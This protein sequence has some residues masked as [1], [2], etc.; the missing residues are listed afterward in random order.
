MTKFCTVCDL[1]KMPYLGCID[2]VHTLDRNEKTGLYTCPI[3]FPRVSNDSGSGAYT[4]NEIDRHDGAR[5]RDEYPDPK[6]KE[7]TSVEEAERLLSLPLFALDTETIEVGSR[8]ELWSIQIT[9][10]T[11]YGY[12]I[13]ISLWGRGDSVCHA[14]ELFIKISTTS[15]VIVHNYLYDAKFIS[16]PNPIDTMIAA[17]LL[18]IP[19]GLKTLA[20]VL[21]GMEMKDYME[22]VQPY[23]RAVAMGYL[24]I[25][26]WDEYEDPPELLDWE[27]SN[28][29]RQ[30]IQS[31]KKPQNIGTKIRARIKKAENNPDFDVYKAWYDIDERER[32]CVEDVL[33]PMRDAG[34]HDVPHDEAVYYSSRDPD[35]TWRVCQKLMLMLRENGLEQVFKMEMAMLPVCLE[36]MQNGMA[37]DVDKL[38]ELADKCI[39]LMQEQ[40][41]KCKDI[42]GYG[43]N[44]NSHDQV[45]QLVYE[46]LGFEV[47]KK[48]KKAKKA[49]TNDKELSKIKH[50]VIKPILEYRKIL[51]VRSSYAEKLPRYVRQ[52]TTTNTGTGFSTTDWIVYPNIKLA[53]T[54]TGRLKVTDPPLQTI[55]VRTELGREVRDAF[56]V[57]PGKQLLFVD[58]C[59]AEGTLVDTPYGDVAIEDLK[60]G[61]IIYSYGDRRPKAAYVKGR[62][63]SGIQ[64]CWKI[65]LDNGESFIATAGHKVPRLHEFQGDDYNLVSV[66]DLL[67]GDRLLPLKRVY[68]NYRSHM[69]SHKAIEYTKEALTVSQLVYGA[70]PEGY[71]VDHIDGN[72]GNDI[73]ENLQ[74]LLQSEHRAKDSPRSYARQD[75][76]L[77]LEKLREALRTKRDYRGYLNLRYGYRKGP[78]L[79]CLYC[80]VDFYAPPC[81]QQKYCSTDC[82]WNARREGHNHKVVSIEYVGEKQ[83]LD[84]EVES[85]SHLF[86]L[87]CGVYTHNSQIEMR[88]LAHESNCQNLIALFNQ[89]G[90]VHSDTATKVF[91]ISREEAREDKYRKP[92][93]NVNFGVVYGISGQ[94]L[95]DLMIENEVEGWTVGDCDRLIKDYFKLYPEV[96]E[97]TQHTIELSYQTGYA[98]DMFGRRCYIPELSSP[99]K[100]VREAGERKAGNQPI[101]G[102]AAGLLKIGTANLIR[103]RDR[104]NIPLDLIGQFHDELGGEVPIDDV[105][106]VAMC[107]VDALCNAVP[108]NVPVLAEAKSGFSWANTQELII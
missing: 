58:L 65:T 26:E 1:C 86:A 98:I 17:W 83:T 78:Q 18:Q 74:Y 55:P 102:G 81:K 80:S 73:P 68:A 48:T 30:L 64:K 23:R 20:Y 82:Y 104:Q 56:I 62:R 85:E 4:T 27:W 16:I 103:E 108:L 46:E 53:G 25:A 8:S 40:A 60:K 77:R 34:L 31:T 76:T 96:R 88:V 36:M 28:D 47:T 38:H 99:H 63:Y 11:G 15:K 79:E 6:Y 32:K 51:K 106:P 41:E 29:E 100:W 14:S 67:V 43:F 50:P 52:R 19:M 44:P 75:H 97:Y 66:S 107:V 13:P 37:V 71:E 10:R 42:A 2:D 89:G 7:V 91:A 35:A 22:Y 12:F 70:R 33:G 90:D 69:Y 61:D 21:C 5:I 84:I 94:G 59:L 45:R 87:S 24:T 9:D 92:I 39:V 49:S 54:D 3:R 57:R 93:K 72:P 95:Y 101:Q 105:I